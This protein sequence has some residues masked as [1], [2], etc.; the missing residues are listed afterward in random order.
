MSNK[1]CITNVFLALPL[2]LLSVQIHATVNQNVSEKIIVTATPSQDPQAPV[3]GFLATKTLSANKLPT[4]IEKTPQSIT[5]ITRDQ[6]DAQDVS[7]VS[8]ALRYTPGVFTEYRGSSNRNDEVFI[9]GYSY[10]PRFLDGLSYGMGASSSTG[11]LDPWLLER[12]EVVKG[13]ASVLYGQV[14]PGGL[15]AMTSKRPTATSIRHIQVRAGNDQLAETAFDF[16]GALSDDN[17]ILYRLNGIAKTQ[18][19]QIKTIKKSV[20]PLL[21]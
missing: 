20:L 6:M 21:Q 14:N 2:S 9:R 1:N 8:Q 19:T 16:S 4:E 17:R 18:H 11:A 7:S 15:V 12:V 5:V 13:P 3:S 10:A